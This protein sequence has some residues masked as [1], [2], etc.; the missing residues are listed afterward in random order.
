M[1][2]RVL[3]VGLVAGAKQERM[4]KSPIS[5]LLERRMPGD[6]EGLR[7]WEV[8]WADVLYHFRTGR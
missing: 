6:G 4:K 7:E 5:K 8:S 3:F 1:C 2:V